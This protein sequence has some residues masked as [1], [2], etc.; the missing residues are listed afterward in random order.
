MAILKEIEDVE[1]KKSGIKGVIAQSLMDM[2]R[3]IREQ[4]SAITPRKG[5]SFRIKDKTFDSKQIMLNNQMRGIKL[6]TN[7]KSI[8]KLKVKTLP[9][10][11]NS[12]E[13]DS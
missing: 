6:K 4:R 12:I 7:L 3:R 1:N 8:E 13:K 11:H 5:K 2:F 9:S 10:K